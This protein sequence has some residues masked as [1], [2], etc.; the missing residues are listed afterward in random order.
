[1]SLLWG[2]INNNMAPFGAEV[3]E[4]QGHDQES[5]RLQDLFNLVLSP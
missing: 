1:M 5:S 2:R 4:V 3:G